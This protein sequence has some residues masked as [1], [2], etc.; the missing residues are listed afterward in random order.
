MRPTTAHLPRLAALG[1]TVVLAGA[2]VACSAEPEPTASGG[3]APTTA[4]TV[5]STSP[6]TTAGTTTTF[7]VVPGQVVMRDYELLPAEATVPVG[8]TVTWQNADEVDHRLLSQDGTT[9]ATGDVAPG[10]AAT[11]TFPAAGAYPYFCDIH[12][13]MVGTVVVG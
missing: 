12:N 11:V 4:S 2:G 6:P 7:V 5:T 3:G 9:I 10:Q 1:L 13:A 8:Q